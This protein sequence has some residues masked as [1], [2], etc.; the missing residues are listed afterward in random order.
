M[1]PSVKKPIVLAV[2]G[3]LFIVIGIALCASWPILLARI[4][5]KELHLAPQSKSFDIWRDSKSM[6]MYL[7]IYFFNWTNPQELKIPGKKPNFAQLGPYTFLE[8]REKVNVVFHDN[9]T[10]SYD[11]MRTWFFEA[12]KS[13]GS[14]HDNITQLNVVALSAAHKV[15]HW[16]FYWQKALNIFMAGIN[17]VHVTKTVD[18]LLFKGY[19]DPLID[20]GKISPVADIPPFDKF[21]WFY[22]RNHSTAFDGHFNMATG[23]KDITTLGVL[24]NWNYNNV[25][26]FFESP[27]NAVEGSA[28][29]FWPPKRTRDEITLFSADICRPLI[30]EYDGI[31]ELHGIEGYQYS[32]GE[33]TLS[34]STKRRYPHEQAKY[35]QTTMAS[36]EDFFAIDAPVN[37][38]IEALED[39]GDSDVVN[40]GQCFCSGDCTPS[41]L[42]NVTACRYGAPAYVS[43]PHFHKA[44]PIYREKVTGMDPNDEKHGFRIILEPTTGIPLDVAARLQI[45]ILLQPSQYINLYKDVPTIYFPMFWFNEHVGITGNLAT[46]LKIFT[47]LP[48][49]GFYSG[50]GL[51]FLG[52]LLVLLAGIIHYLDRR[53]NATPIAIPQANMIPSQKTE[54]VYLDASVPLDDD[55]QTRKDRQLYPKLIGN[56]VGENQLPNL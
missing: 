25:S 39:Y 28:G 15:R 1:M 21:G 34:N 13:N 20:M 24:R 4:F 48:T 38:T 17:D 53:K 36:T 23:E 22:M 27:C 14:L 18:E 43:L 3:N 45:N 41:G 5:I 40:V 6:P 51:I 8:R 31:V 19:E 10:V 35:F 30:Y 44:D 26:T 56:G 2:I 55:N 46:P 9:G 32:I 33:K 52:A 16:T 37:A 11:Q 12:G 49:I 42:I 29:E 54:L 50:I 47:Q 7:E